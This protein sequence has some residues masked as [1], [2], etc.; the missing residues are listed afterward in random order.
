MLSTHNYEFMNILYNSLKSGGT[1]DHFRWIK[2]PGTFLYHP[3]LKDL[4]TGLTILCI[5]KKIQPYI[6]N[7]VL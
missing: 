6:K 3:L 7:H 5:R 4:K 2:V 1:K